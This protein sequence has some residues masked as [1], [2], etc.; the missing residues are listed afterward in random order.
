VKQAV[1][2]PHV[3]RRVSAIVDDLEVP[4][5]L[6]AP[7]LALLLAVAMF[8]PDWPARSSRSRRNTEGIDSPAGYVGF[9]SLWGVIACVALAID[10]WQQQSAWITMM[11]AAGGFAGATIVSVGYAQQLRLGLARIDGTVR[12]PETWAVPSPPAPPIFIGASTLGL[13]SALVLARGCWHARHQ[14]EGSRSCL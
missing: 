14:G 2:F 6:L 5:V 11:V 9:L 8:L 4:A 1:Q 13:F 12:M 10:V 7:L 3:N